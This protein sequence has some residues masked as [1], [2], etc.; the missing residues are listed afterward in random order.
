MG[1]CGMCSVAFST[2]QASLTS[3]P[4]P[5]NDGMVLIASVTI[6]S[7]LGSAVAELRLLPFLC[8]HVSCLGDC[9]NPS[10]TQVSH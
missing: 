2:L 9:S 10:G 6:S 1:D 8:A 4:W 3:S 7:V 5:E